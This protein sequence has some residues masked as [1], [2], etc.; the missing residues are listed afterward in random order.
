MVTRFVDI[1]NPQEAPR[2]TVTNMD[3]SDGK[4]LEA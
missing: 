4:E 3:D 1:F 2:D